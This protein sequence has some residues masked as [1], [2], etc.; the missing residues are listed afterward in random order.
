MIEGL[1]EDI[2]RL[3]GREMVESW[4]I[5]DAMLAEPPIVL[6]VRTTSLLILG[7]G[8]DRRDFHSGWLDELRISLY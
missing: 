8:V 5:A 4:R 1:R 3:A 6:I 2:I 7:E